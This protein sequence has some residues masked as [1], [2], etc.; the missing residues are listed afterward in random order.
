MIFNQSFGGNGAGGGFLVTITEQ[1]PHYVMDKT[2]GEIKAAVA[3]GVCPIFHF[4]PDNYW[5]TLA[6]IQ[7]NN[8]GAV[9]HVFDSGDV[10]MSYIAA[11]DTDYPYRMGGSNN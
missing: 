11:S 2:L 9:V 7:P 4:V 6:Y 3:N 1:Y 10:I 5:G 8:S